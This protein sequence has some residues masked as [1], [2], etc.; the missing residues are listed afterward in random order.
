M[1]RKSIRLLS[2]E[3]TAERVSNAI[4]EFIAK[5]PRSQARRSDDP[6]AAAM[7][8]ANRAAARAALTAGS[9]SLPP[10]P[11]G[12]LTVVPE[13]IGV[14]KIQAQL[15][16][17]VAKIYGKSAELTQ[18]HML[19]CLFRHSAAQAVQDLAVRGGQRVLVK[20]A[21]VKAIQSAARKIGIRVTQRGFVSGLSRWLP[22]VGA[23]GVGGYAYYDT[24]QVARA[25]IELFG[26][27]DRVD[28]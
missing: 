24:S 8:K 11:L 20:K 5:V 23:V 19:Y 22:V 27:N 13:L 21:T 14:W 6:L 16:S 12:L 10:G 1:T 17:D 26:A 7:E 3:S 4:L 15:V 28:S 25:A 2:K 18:E 9:L